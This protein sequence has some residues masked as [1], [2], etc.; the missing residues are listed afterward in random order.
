MTGQR[1]L[2]LTGKLF[3]YL[4]GKMFLYLTGQRLLYLTGQRLL[5][6]TGQWLL[7]LEIP[8]GLLGTAGLMFLGAGTGNGSGRAGYRLATPS[9]PSTLLVFLC[10][11]FSFSLSDWRLSALSLVW[12]GLEWA[13]EKLSLS[14]GGGGAFFPFPFLSRV[15][16]TGLGRVGGG[17]GVGARCCWQ[18]DRVRQV[19]GS[20]WSQ[21]GLASF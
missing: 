16:G 20:R 17:R 10:R 21:G 14:A 2:Y 19:L 6:L 12:L 4:T 9:T 7:Y 5:Y 3:L 8:S 1:L 18:V 11:T 13:G 15:L